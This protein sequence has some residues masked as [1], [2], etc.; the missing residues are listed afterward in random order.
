MSVAKTL[1]GRRISNLLLR[2]VVRKNLIW[3]T[4]QSSRVDRTATPYS[5][6]FSG[7]QNRPWIRREVMGECKGYSKGAALHLKTDRGPL[8]ILQ[9]VKEYA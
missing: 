1:A 3:I 2:P 7:V 9:V 5:F 6:D 8:I 4:Q